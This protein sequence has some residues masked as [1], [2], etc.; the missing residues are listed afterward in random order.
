MAYVVANRCYGGFGLS[1]KGLITYCEKKY[2]QAFLYKE[3][4]EDNSV[5]GKYQKISYSETCDKNQSIRYW[6]IPEDK[7]DVVEWDDINNLIVDNYDIKR[8]DPALIATIREL[9]EEANGRYA[10][11][12]VVTI[13]DDVQW[14]IREYDG[15]ETVE[16]KHRSW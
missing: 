8:D 5:F 11:L 7:G 2:G 12:E 9:G 15:W 3:E 14:V 16:E 13:P 1:I 10:N 4:D 6:V